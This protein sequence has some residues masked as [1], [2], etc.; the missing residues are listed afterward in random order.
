MGGLRAM[1]SKLTIDVKPRIEDAVHKSK[2]WKL[3]DITAAAQWR[4]ICL[5]DSLPAS[6]VS[7]L[8]YT[9]AGIALLALASNAVHKL[10]KWQRS[11]RHPSGKA[12]IAFPPQLQ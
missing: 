8:I 6:K 12:T 4:T 5:P 2:G 1:D 9:N 7:R 3:T 11:D 10:W